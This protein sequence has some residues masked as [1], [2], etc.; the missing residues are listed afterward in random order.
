MQSI[1]RGLDFYST[2]LLCGKKQHH[3]W[4]SHIRV[5]APELCS[6]WLCLPSLSQ[7][8]LSSSVSQK[9]SHIATGFL[10]FTF[11]KYVSIS[12]I[13]QGFVLIGKLL[14]SVTS[15]T[16]LYLFAQK[17]KHTPPPKPNNKKPKPQTKPKEQS[18]KHYMV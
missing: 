14:S 10:Y 9:W 4:F 16:L 8:I 13:C 12:C 7:R 11:K 3:V 15:S 6:C 1:T 2:A 5:Q 18:I 17:K